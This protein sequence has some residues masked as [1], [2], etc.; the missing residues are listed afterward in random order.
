LWFKS[1]TMHN[2]RC[3]NMLFLYKRLFSKQWCLPYMQPNIP[4]LHF[5]QQCFLYGM[6]V[7]S[8]L[9]IKHDLPLMYNKVFK[10]SHLWFLRMLVMFGSNNL[11]GRWDL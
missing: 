9:F 3:N 6:F 2:M 5:V 11:L 7:K 8:V 1:S 10:L 4:E